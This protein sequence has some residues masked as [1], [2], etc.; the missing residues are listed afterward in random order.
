MS[1][2]DDEIFVDVIVRCSILIYMYFNMYAK[3]VWIRLLDLTAC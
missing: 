2:L 3:V 1:S